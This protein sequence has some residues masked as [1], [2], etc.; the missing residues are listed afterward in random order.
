MISDLVINLFTYILSICISISIVIDRMR[1]DG[2]GRGKGERWGWDVKWIEWEEEM[3][4]VYV[5]RG[6]Y[7][8]N[9]GRKGEGHV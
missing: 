5:E 7:E 1:I 3:I 4:D 8:T 2:G 9:R 6:I